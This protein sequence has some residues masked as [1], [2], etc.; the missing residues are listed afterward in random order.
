MNNENTVV[1]GLVNKAGEIVYVGQ[2]CRPLIRLRQHRK[3]YGQEIDMAILQHTFENESASE[4]EK[5]WI[6]KFCT[7]GARLANIVH[8]QGDKAPV[9]IRVPAGWLE[10]IDRAARRLG[11]NRTAIIVSAAAEK[12]ERMEG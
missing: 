7:G 8:A 11:I 10:R 9:M 3:K 6:E 12:L 4:A 5:K 2:S 1:Y